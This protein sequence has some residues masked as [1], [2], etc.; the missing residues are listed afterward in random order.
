[1]KIWLIERKEIGRV[2]RKRNGG[3]PKNGKGKERKRKEKVLRCA[4]DLFL[5]LIWDNSFMSFGN[6]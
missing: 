6:G 5:Y 3:G 4:T 2:V 1:M